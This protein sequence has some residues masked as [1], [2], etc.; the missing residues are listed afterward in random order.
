MLSPPNAGRSLLFNVFA[1]CTFPKSFDAKITKN[2]AKISVFWAYSQ[3]LVN[4]KAHYGTVVRTENP[5]NANFVPF[6]WISGRAVNGK[7]VS[8]FCNYSF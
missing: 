1:F 2:D 7:Y 5:V 6:G 3:M 4:T 8:I